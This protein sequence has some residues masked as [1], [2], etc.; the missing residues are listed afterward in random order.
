MGL[1][2]AE[3]EARDRHARRDHQVQG[4]RRRALAARARARQGHRRR[5]RWCADLAQ[6]AAPA[7]RR[8]HRLGQV[9]RHQ[10]D[11]AVAALQEHGRARAPDHDRSEDARAVGVRGH[12][13]PARAR[14]HRHEAGRQRVALVRGGDGAALPA[15]VGARR[16]QHRRLQP[17]GEGRQRCGQADPRS[18]DDG[19]GVERSDVRPDARS[20]ISRRCPTSS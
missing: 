13:A 7:D 14:G 2:I 20:R 1:E 11:G 4:L 10:R 16:A 9:R 15:D 3:R 8:H 12:S 6:D 19:D 5:S 17:Q 18:G